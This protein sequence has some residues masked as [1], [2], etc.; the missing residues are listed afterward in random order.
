MSEETANISLEHRAIRND[1]FLDIL[2][3]RMLQDTKWGEQNHD[4]VMWSAILTEEV[5]E[6]C[7]AAT[8]YRFDQG[9]VN[10][11]RE[12]VV[13]VAAVAVAILECLEQ[14]KWKWGD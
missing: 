11:F 5:G 8:K 1:I 13:Q 6:M 14:A 2:R 3:E 7:E 10:Q 9:N 12:E 4:P